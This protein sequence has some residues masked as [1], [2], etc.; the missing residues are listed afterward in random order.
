M[1]WYSYMVTETVQKYI[2]VEANSE[3]EAEALALA[4]DL[5]KNFDDYNK[6]ALLLEV[7]DEEH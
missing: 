3:E 5:E 6:G 7:D 4:E 2:W 1:K